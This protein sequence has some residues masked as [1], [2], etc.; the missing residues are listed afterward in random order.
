MSEVV[1]IET[2]VGRAFRDYG[3]ARMTAEQSGD[4]HDHL[5]AGRAYWR[6]YREFCPTDA[7]PP[8]GRAGGAP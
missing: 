5:A 2:K 1:R 3:E 4:I 8:P 6:F 7:A